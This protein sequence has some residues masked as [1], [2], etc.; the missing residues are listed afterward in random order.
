MRVTVREIDFVAA[1][2][3]IANAASPIAIKKQSTLRMPF[4]FI[5]PKTVDE[6]S[7]TNDCDKWL[8]L[9]AVDWSKQS[10]A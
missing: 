8:A 10:E 1:L 4:I 7:E 3:C 2:A 6:T 9:G 5:S